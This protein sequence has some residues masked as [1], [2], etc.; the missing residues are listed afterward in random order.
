MDRYPHTLSIAWTTGGDFDGTG[1]YIPGETTA[2]EIEGR[3]EAN[4]K[5]NLVR[6]DDGSQIVYAWAFFCYPPE[7]DI[8]FGAAATLVHETGTWTG[9][10]KRAAVNQK[11]AQIWL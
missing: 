2:V 1:E 11:G 8:P 9:T 6:A 3:A 7:T 10:V 5:G 4:G